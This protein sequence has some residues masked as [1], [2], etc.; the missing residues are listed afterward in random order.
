MSIPYKI[1]F[2]QIQWESRI[3]GVRHKCM[4]YEGHRIRLV[5]Y[6]K[7]MPPHWCEKGHT[8]ILLSGKMAIEFSD[9]EITYQEGDGILIPDGPEHQHKGRVLSGRATVFFIEKA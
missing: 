9:T 7:E 2:D 1:P 3:P 4:D 8:G 5:E 6:T